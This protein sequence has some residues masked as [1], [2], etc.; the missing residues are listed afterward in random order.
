MRKYKGV[1][2]SYLDR[3]DKL[4]HYSLFSFFLRL[5]IGSFSSSL[6]KKLTLPQTH[7]VSPYNNQRKLIF[8][9]SLPKKYLFSLNPL[10]SLQNTPLCPPKLSLPPSV[11]SQL[12]VRLSFFQENEKKTLCPL[13]ALPQ[14]RYPYHNPQKCLSCHVTP[15]SIQFCLP[16]SNSY[17][18][19]FSNNSPIIPLWLRVLSSRL[20]QPIPRL[21]KNEKIKQK[22]CPIFEGVYKYTYNRKTKMGYLPFLMFLLSGV[23]PI[24][25]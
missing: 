24:L 21:M 11:S 16:S 20:I 1:S 14:A 10:A 17:V 5:F 13:P 6:W 8:S 18:P 15:F 9:L 22:K 4:L 23:F 25:L 2:K 12:F 19:S 3:T 7:P